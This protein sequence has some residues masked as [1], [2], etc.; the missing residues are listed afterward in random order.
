M[1]EVSVTLL[2][3]SHPNPD[4]IGVM[5]VGPGGTSAGKAVIMRNTG[6]G[7]GLNNAVFIF[8]DNTPNSLP[9]IGPITNGFYKPTDL[10]SGAFPTAGSATALA[11]AGCPMLSTSGVT[12]VAIGVAAGGLGAAAAA[13]RFSR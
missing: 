10:G 4:D 9:S 13:A 2:G 5:L 11:G 8:Q 3:V 12:V 6:S 1:A 7:S